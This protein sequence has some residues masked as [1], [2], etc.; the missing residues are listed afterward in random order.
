M[1]APRL[2]SD[3]LVLRLAG[4]EDV[5]A[6][7]RY[8]R[9]NE[10]HLA[11]YDPLKPANFYTEPYWAARVRHSQDEF[12]DD[13]A[14]RTFLFAK[15][16]PSVVIGTVSLSAILRGP[17]QY[18]NLGYSLAETAQGH[19]YMIEILPELIGYAFGPLKLHRIQANYMPH[20]VRSGKLL[21]RLGFVVE[22]YARD[23]LM[24]AGQWED[25][26]L[27]SLTNQAWAL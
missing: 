5:P 16:A 4:A 10:A 11:P 3:R 27:T 21:R 26:V 23:Y 17:A 7:I 12:R 6:I 1:I 18:A 2:E 25:H 20:N 9:E 13:R 22:G 15:A 14:M 8:Y 19:G 24:I